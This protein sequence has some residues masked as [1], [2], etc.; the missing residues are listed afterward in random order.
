LDWV[1]SSKDQYA[2]LALSP[3]LWV[4]IAVL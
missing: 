1:F 4:Q 3:I 2:R